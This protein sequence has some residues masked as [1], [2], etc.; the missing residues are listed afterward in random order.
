M[1]KERRKEVEEEGVRR[2]IMRESVIGEG[3]ERERTCE[4][5]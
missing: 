2:I 5:K 1:R 3:R 4:N